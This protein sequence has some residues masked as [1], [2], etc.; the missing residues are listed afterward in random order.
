MKRLAILLTA[1]AVFGISAQAAEPGTPEG[2]VLFTSCE[3]CHSIKLGEPHKVGPN[4]HGIMGQPAASRDGFT[5]S[6]ALK[7]SD[8]TWNRD[9][10]IAWMVATES[11][12]PGT[13]MLYHNHMTPP[14]VMQLADYIVAESASVDQ[15]DN[16]IQMLT[17]EFNNAEQAQASIDAPPSE[18]H[19]HLHISINPANLS[20]TWQASHALLVQFRNN[21]PNGELTRE[22]VYIF[23]PS[24]G[25]IRQETWMPTAETFP[26]EISSTDVTRFPEHCDTWWLKKEKAWVGEMSPETCQITSRSGREIR[27]GG[28]FVFSSSEYL[29]RE[30]L[31]TN[32]MQPIDKGMSPDHLVLKRVSSA[33]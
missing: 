3:G 9:T 2:T 11:M 4:L 18:K 31:F 16:L 33:Q 26:A 25:R 27:V 20:S 28:N 30:D 7:N 24:N 17:G 32:D 1:I 14:E 15:L 29:H 12:A 19:P 22:R 5:Y 6:D 8:I 21:G 23:R 13:W 10:L